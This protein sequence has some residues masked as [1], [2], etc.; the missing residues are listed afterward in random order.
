MVT[1]ELCVYCEGS[2]RQRAAEDKVVLIVR[3]VPEEL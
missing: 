2:G 3:L 1:E